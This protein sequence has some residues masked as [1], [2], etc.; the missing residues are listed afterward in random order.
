MFIFLYSFL[1]KKKLHKKK[2]LNEIFCNY[3]YIYLCLTQ[4]ITL[5]VNNFLINKIFKKNVDFSQIWFHFERCSQ[6]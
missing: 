4:Y 6:F 1:A 2:F 5:F 3:K